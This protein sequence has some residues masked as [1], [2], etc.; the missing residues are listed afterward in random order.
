MTTAELMLSNAVKS[1]TMALKGM[2][3]TMLANPITGII[4]L[5]TTLAS[6]VAMFGGEGRYFC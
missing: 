6:A 3:A 2:W 1:T 5:V 4:T